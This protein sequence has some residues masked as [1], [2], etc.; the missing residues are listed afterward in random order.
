M[1]AVTPPEQPSTLDEA[2]TEL[3]TAI[4]RN[5]EPR[6]SAVLLVRSELRRRARR[7]GG[8]DAELDE[9]V[10][11]ALEAFIRAV[12]DGRVHVDTAGAYLARTL[13]HRLIDTHRRS[14]SGSG[15]RRTVPLET[16]DSST[17]G[18]EDERLARLLDADAARDDVLS[19][20]RHAA[21]AGR[22]TVVRVVAEW[23]DI[24]ART[25]AEPSSRA[26]GDALGLSHTA[27][28]DA[29]REFRGEHLPKAR[30]HA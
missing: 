15:E 14:F 26:V 25:G 22:S 7:A 16:A 13:K 2:A 1:C 24:A 28:M 20:L 21:D 6:A 29:L 23:L 17:I 19:A 12:L 10:D 27:V 8:A 30:S 18:A 5:D 4:A 9:I 11:A 3:A